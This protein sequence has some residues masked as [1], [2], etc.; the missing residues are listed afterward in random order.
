MGE[1]KNTLTSLAMLQK[2]RKLKIKDSAENKAK[3]NQ[4]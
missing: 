3:E 1:C 2:E 4:E